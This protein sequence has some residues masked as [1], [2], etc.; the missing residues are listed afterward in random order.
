[1]PH[2]QVIGTAWDRCL[3]DYAYTRDFDNTGW[4]WEFLRHNRSYAR[5]YRLCRA[6]HPL[7]IRHVSGTTLYR[8]KRRFPAAEAWGLVLFSDPAKSAQHVDVFWLPDLLHHI[9]YCDCNFESFDRAEMIS[10]SDFAARRSIMLDFG[11]EHLRLRGQ[12][13]SADML[14]KNGTILFGKNAVTFKHMGLATALQHY[15]TLKL[16]QRFTGDKTRA[17]F[18]TPVQTSKYLNYLIALE[19]YLEGRSYRDI[20]NVLFG[21]EAV[22][23]HWTSDSRGYKSAT[24]RAV[25][26]GIALMNSGYRDLL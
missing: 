8:L 21:K 3:E 12:K 9:A 24:R 22:G 20:A 4:A 25:A 16:L 18:K 23:A 13:M 1:M 14:I 15:E 7:A 6:G 17:G 19:G 2:V 26:A 10:L 5:D 11:G